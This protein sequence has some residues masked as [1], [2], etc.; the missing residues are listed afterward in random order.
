MINKKQKTKGAMKNTS[1]V[2]VAAVTGAVVGAGVIAAGI[3]AM[4]NDKNKAKAKKIINEVKAKA[5]SY[6]KK[7][8]N[9]VDDSKA[10]LEQTATVAEGSKKKVKKIWQKS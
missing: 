4:G 1:N 3:V 10:K 8:Q 5:S 7:T 6:M 2:V 9:Q